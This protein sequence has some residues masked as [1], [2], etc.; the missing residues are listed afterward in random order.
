MGAFR[1]IFIWNTMLHASIL[2]VKAR[3][4][5]VIGTLRVSQNLNL[6]GE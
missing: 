4:N 6:S 5:A 3:H 2:S 1:L